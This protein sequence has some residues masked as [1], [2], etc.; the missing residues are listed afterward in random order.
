MTKIS[1]DQHSA[2]QFEE[3]YN[4]ITF[5]TPNGQ[6]LAV[7]M[8]DEGFEIGLCSKPQMPVIWFSANNDEIKRLTPEVE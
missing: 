4:S 6:V 3:V 8:R 5:K 1:V 7:C 2:I